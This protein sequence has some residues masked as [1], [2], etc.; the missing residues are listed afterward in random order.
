M[1]AFLSI[2][3]YYPD[4]HREDS[5]SIGLII[6]PIDDFPGEIRISQQR[7]QRINIAFGLKASILLTNYFESISIV[8]FTYDK[9]VYLSKYENGS[10]RF[11]EPKAVIL[12]DNKQSFNDLYLK[13][14]AD[15]SELNHDHS[16][17]TV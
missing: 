7:I 17:Q 12:N 3:K 10:I 15:K 6:P 16:L 4:T 9:L 13:L 8:D 1:K 11:S 14:V 2:I 5:F